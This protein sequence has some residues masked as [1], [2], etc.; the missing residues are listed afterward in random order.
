MINSSD[1]RKNGVPIQHYFFRC[2]LNLNR[3]QFKRTKEGKQMLNFFMFLN[4]TY[5]NKITSCASKD[6]KKNKPE[7]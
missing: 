6:N 4:L 5:R 2:K 3:M 1:Q 7:A